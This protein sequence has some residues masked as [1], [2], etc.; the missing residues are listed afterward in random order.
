M[1]D[2]S[3]PPSLALPRRAAM[4][5]VEHARLA[6]GLR[7]LLVERRELPLVHLQFG[8]L[9]GAEL[10]P[11]G[12]AGLATLTAALLDEG[13]A[14]RSSSEI[15]GAI[16]SLGGHLSTTAGWEACYARST[17]LRSALEPA[18]ALLA[19][20]IRS[21]TLPET[22]FE[23]L[24][25]QRQAELLHRRS[26]PAALAEERLARVLY[27]DGVYGYLSSGDETTT[28]A[29]RHE[30][31]RAFFRH[32]APDRGWLIAVGALAPGELLAQAEA[33][34]GDWSAAGTI[35]PPGGST[36]ALPRLGRTVDV[37]DR[38]GAAQTELRLGHGGLPKLHPDRVPLA[39]GNALLGGKF[40]S[41]INLNLRE[42]RGL[43]Y[44]AF[45]RLAER[46]GPGP[47]SVGAA[48]ATEHVGLAVREV[49]AEM[50]RLRQEP[51]AE[52]ELADTR[53]YLL[54]V[55]PY[56]LQ[57][58]DDLAHKLDELA[59]YGLPDDY[60][61]SRLREIEA[62]RPEDVRQA[63]AKHLRPESAAI[64]AAGPAAELVP[65]LEGLAE[66]R[67]SGGQTAD[68]AVD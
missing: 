17:V 56:Q 47:F 35:A 54:G 5:R 62:V 24:R 21:A 7:L 61:E 23:R 11:P 31:S 10:D 68:V 19:E 16:E 12:R 6:N 2:R 20:V 43:T 44:G 40:T 65:Q 22:E 59:I 51:P 55:F 46:R 64:V 49:L 37:I 29:L 39:V 60:H 13:T 8:G 57:T 41:R 45:S 38:P 14:R 4:P 26:Q 42:R 32:L 34:F 30:D 15:A 67:V 48:V 50:E 58:S 28:A 63:A 36:E 25:R 18:L 33:L 9:A 53:S 1:I 27:G 66:V 3:A 52:A